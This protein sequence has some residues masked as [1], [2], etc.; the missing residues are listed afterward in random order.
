MARPST[1]SVSKGERREERGTHTQRERQ[2]S[3]VDLELWKGEE[4][5]REELCCGTCRVC[6]KR[7]GG[8]KTKQEKCCQAEEEEERKCEFF[9]QIRRN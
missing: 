1:A 3:L 7:G 4:R 9:R 2:L 5:E 8:W 6:R